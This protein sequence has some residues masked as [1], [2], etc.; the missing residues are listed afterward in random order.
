MYRFCVALL[1]LVAT[2]GCE[3][4]PT[5][6][7]APTPVL[8][9]SQ[10]AVSLDRT[11]TFQVSAT[12][13][14]ADVPT[15]IT[16]AATWRSDNAEVATVSAGLILA[17]GPGTANITAE[18]AGQTKAVAVTVRRRTYLTG[19]VT[20]RNLAGEETI[21][22]V[23]FA[24]DGNGAGGRNGSGR[25]ASFTARMSLNPA[26]AVVQPGNRTLTVRTVTGPNGITASYS[27]TWT[28][29]LR[30]RDLDTSEVIATL[31][32]AVKTVKADTRVH[33]VDWTIV[34]PAFTS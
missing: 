11:L 25:Q 30:V 10:T 32:I 9:I 27:I 34:I 23:Y 22:G 12:S 33:D 8:S 5:S 14:V 29:P 4:T 7:P 13:L 3:S 18:H 17:V 2:C 6:P 24:L 31:P 15:D 26:G 16:A 28:A 19:E 21:D 1:V 20:V